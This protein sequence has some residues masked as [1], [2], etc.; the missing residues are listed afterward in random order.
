[1]FLNFA[2]AP[3]RTRIPFSICASSNPALGDGA[4]GGAAVLLGNGKNGNSSEALR[5]C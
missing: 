5:L 2:L 1:M 3:I 4:C